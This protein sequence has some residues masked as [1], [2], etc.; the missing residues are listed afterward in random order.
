MK[1]RNKITLIFVLLSALLLLLVFLSIYFSVQNH[2]H[3]EFYSRLSQR[4]SIAAQAYLEKDELS[5]GIY[6]EIRK[7]HLQILP[8]EEERILEVDVTKSALISPQALPVEREFFEEVFSTGHA[9]VR[10]EKSYYTAILYEDNQG[11]FIV[12][13]SAE[14][15]YG[16]A[17]MQNLAK[18]LLTVYVLSLIILFVIGQYYAKRVLK[19]IS[20]ITCQVNRI[21]AKNLHLRLVNGH[22]NDELGELSRTFNNMLDR[23]ENSFEMKNSFVRNAS[24]ELKNPLTAIIGQTEVALGNA[25]TE[26][27]YIATLRTIEKEASRLNEL[28]NALLELAYAENDSKGLI[29]DNI[30]ADELLMELKMDFDALTSNKINCDFQFL[31]EDSNK[32]IFKGN[33]RLIRVALLNV[34]D[35]AL[36]YS[37]NGNIDLGIQVKE[38][39]ILISIKD[40]GIGIPKDDLKNVFEPFSRGSNARGHKGFGFGLPLSHKIVRLHGGELQIDSEIG[41]GTH[42]LMQ[43]PTI[44]GNSGKA[45]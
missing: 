45:F 20:D 38:D 42:V 25:R 5:T 26:R 27:E 9:E 8:N 6:E 35:N 12:V 11:D 36:K 2:T 10:I 7:K 40:E 14:D 39:M 37:K 3:N 1:I 41:K 21:R 34:L 24:H 17:K 33:H 30:R 28:I 31:P 4:A 22:K 18:T 16:T 43:L 44:N 13:L 32:L 19:P 15:L 23:L 29:I